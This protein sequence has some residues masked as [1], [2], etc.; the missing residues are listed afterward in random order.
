MDEWYGVREGECYRH[1]LTG[2][3]VHVSRVREHEGF[4]GLVRWETLNSGTIDG[5]TS[6]VQEA[7]HFLEDFLDLSPASMASTGGLICQP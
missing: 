7:Q 6:E 5:V 2:T 3:A 1:R 4:T